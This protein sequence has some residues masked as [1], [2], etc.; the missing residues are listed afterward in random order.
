M[1]PKLRFSHSASVLPVDDLKETAAYY[2]EAFGFELSFMWGEPAHYAVLKRDGVGIHLTEREDT[3]T[4]IRPNTV[5]VFVHDV[6]AL[7]EEFKD[8]VIDMFAPP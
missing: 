4:K 7:S 6:D 5:Y 8:K 2:Q 3:S 1:T